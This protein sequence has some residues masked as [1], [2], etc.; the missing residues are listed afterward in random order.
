MHV[1]APKVV[2]LA[3]AVEY[4]FLHTGAKHGLVLVDLVDLLARLVLELSL[5]LS[6]GSLCSGLLQNK[7]TF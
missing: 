4:G 5:C 3:L 2:A 7:G 1:R 6:L